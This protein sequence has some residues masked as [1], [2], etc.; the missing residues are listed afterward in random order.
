MAHNP[1]IQ[2]LETRTFD[3]VIRGG[4]VAT[5]N[6][7]ENLD[8]GVAGGKIVGLGVIPAGRAGQEFDAT[9]LTV[10]P[11]VIDTQVH[12]REPGLE[13]KED[14]ASGTAGAAL[15]GVTAIFEMP[16]TNPNTLDAAAINDK[17]ARARGRAWVDHAFFM[18]A[19]DEN[20][21]QLGE[22]EK[23]PGCAGVKI[24][25]GSS[26]GSLLVADDETLEEV[27]RHGRRRVAIHAEDEMR[28]RER[29]ALV[30]DGADPDQHPVWRDVETAVRA[31]TR[32]LKIARKAGRRIHVLHVSTADEMPILAAHKDIAT[33]EVLTH[34][35]TLS[36]PDCYRRLGTYAQMNP[37]VRDAHHQ[38]GIWQA[39]RAGVVDCIGSDHAPHTREEKD[40]PY[41]QSPSGMPGVQTLLPVMLD[42]VA[43]GRL[44]LQRL[45]DLT[46]A[47]PARIFNIRNKG[48]IALG[49]DADFSVVDLTAQRTITNEWMATKAGWTPYHGMEVTGWPRATIIRG[50]IVMREDELQG[51]ALGQ[52]VQFQ[53]T[54][55]PQG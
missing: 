3:L 24:F 1:D 23:L 34:H 22:L 52:P 15:G 18:G 40:R 4:H 36:A 8:I 50:H 31:T 54:I 48:R 17:L 49:Y 25:M 14:L 2:N 41:P 27:L 26:T 10:L 21:S 53:E 28:L 39:L 5:P 29:L 42:H 44:T 11:G 55:Q 7:L 16:N 43:K 47:G 45:I 13:H 51:K 9:G 30:K 46:S 6:G 37:P 12:F 32:I 38:A 35:L 33:V 19:S 20:A